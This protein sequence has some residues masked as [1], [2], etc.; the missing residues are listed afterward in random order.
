MG[1]S[2]SGCPEDDIADGVMTIVEVPDGVTMD[3]CGTAALPPPQPAMPR[4]TQKTA[5]VRA[6]HFV[7]RLLPSAFGI[8][9]PPEILEGHQENQ[10]EC[11]QRH[12]TLPGNGCEAYGN[13]KWQ[14][15][16]AA[17]RYG[18]RKRRGR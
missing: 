9:E 4:K 6:P 5:T 10:S 15:R 1:C 3:C 2:S 12:H 11:Q 16:A 18:D 13:R 7:K 17:R 14:H 8:S